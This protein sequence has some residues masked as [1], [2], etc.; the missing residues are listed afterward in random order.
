MTRNLVLFLPENNVQT[1]RSMPE[2]SAPEERARW[3][4]A[5]VAIWAVLPYSRLDQLLL[6]RLYVCT[7]WFLLRCRKRS[8][9]WEAGLR[10]LK[11]RFNSARPKTS[12]S[13]SWM[14][15]LIWMCLWPRGLTGSPWMFWKMYQNISSGLGRDNM[16]AQVCDD[17]V[18]PGVTARWEVSVVGSLDLLCV[19]IEDLRGLDTEAS[20]LGGVAG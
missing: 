6:R 18:I 20:G 9:H 4:Q 17:V 10:V 5:P 13:V 1:H 14:A 11:L 12:A 7:E 2:L 3:E 19:P 15:V 16:S 8:D